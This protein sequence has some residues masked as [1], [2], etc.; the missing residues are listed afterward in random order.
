MKRLIG[1][2]MICLLVSVNLTACKKKETPPDNSTSISQS[3]ENSPITLKGSPDE[4]YYM[5]V[6]VSGVEYWFPVFQG[7]KDAAK[8]LGVNCYYM[9]TTEYDA[10]KQVEVF[11]QILA[12]NP[13]GVLVHP[14]TAESFVAPIKRATDS[15]VKIVTFAAD[16]PE[17]ERCAY[18]TSDNIKEGNTAAENIA[19]ELKG[20]GKV[21]IMRNPGQTNHEIRCDSFIEYMKA[22]YPDIEVVA[23]EVSGQNADKTY[24]SVM[25]V[26]QAHPGLA[27]VFTPEASSAIGAA[28]A[29]IELGGGKQSLLISCCDTS[30]QVLDLL[31]DDQFFNAIAPDQY[32]QGYIGM[33]N[34][35]FAAHNELLRPMNSRES[36]G[37]NLWQIPYCDN[38]LSIVTKENADSFY[39]SNYCKKIGVADTGEMLSPYLVK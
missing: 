7:M 21:M 26:A 5:C 35:Y 8:A 14:I 6:P 28:Q 32:L 38:G 20:K 4:S 29:G 10:A 16:S 37:Q 33:L 1:I 2:L 11:D 34:L 30:E 27:A 23:E 22:N 19:K 9:G 18:V 31:K 24:Q 3:Q 39:I 15:N 13:T 12:M 25:T 17:S 36:E